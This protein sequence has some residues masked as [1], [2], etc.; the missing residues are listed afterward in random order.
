MLSPPHSSNIDSYM[1]KHGAT[2]VTTKTILP[3]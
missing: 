1:P 2:V 3:P